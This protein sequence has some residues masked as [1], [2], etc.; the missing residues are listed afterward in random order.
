MLGCHYTQLIL[1]Y[2]GEGEIFN[3]DHFVEFMTWTLSANRTYITIMP[4]YLIRDLLSVDDSL[5]YVCIEKKIKNT[6]PKHYTSHEFSIFHPNSLWT[7]C[8][9][10]NQLNVKHA[11]IFLRW[12]SHQL[13][14]GFS[15][16][17]SNLFENL[18]TFNN[19]ALWNV[20]V[21]KIFR[22]I[23][24]YYLNWNVMFSK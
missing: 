23:F 5:L 7:L 9:Q 16:I 20:A 3:F 4:L 19:K 6:R 12:K 13:K 17:K 10:W 11:I 8:I 2:T 22:N 24:C 18:L 15:L 14:P 21:P 1:Y